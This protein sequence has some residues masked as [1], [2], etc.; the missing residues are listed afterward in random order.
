M[1]PLDLPLPPHDGCARLELT[2]L[3][4]SIEHRATRR[5]L[6]AGTAPIA[7]EFRSLGHSA[8][9]RSAQHASACRDGGGRGACVAVA[10]HM[11]DEV[12]LEGFA[13]AADDA[14]YAAAR[15]VFERNLRQYTQGA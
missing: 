3:L 6:G 14:V 7:A 4:A 2:R 15:E 8:N 10:N 12:A 5:S 13:D 1:G 11:Y 9:S